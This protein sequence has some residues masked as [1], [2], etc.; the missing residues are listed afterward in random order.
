MRIGPGRHLRG[1]TL[2][3]NVVKPEEFDYFHELIINQ[4]HYIM[5]TR[6]LSQP[7]PELG[8]WKVRAAWFH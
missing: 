3:R 5:V 7:S 6:L 1:R 2:L 4:V 8:N